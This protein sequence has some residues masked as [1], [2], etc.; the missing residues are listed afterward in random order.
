MHVIQFPVIV[1]VKLS[2]TAIRCNISDFTRSTVLKLR[3]ALPQ[4]NTNN[5]K[6]TELRGQVANTP[7]YSRGSWLKSR[8]GDRL[9][10]LML[11]VVFLSP[12]R[13]MPL[14]YLK[15]I[16]Q[17]RFFSILTNSSFTYDP[18]IRHSIV[19]V[20]EKPSLNNLQTDRFIHV[21]NIPGIG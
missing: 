18:F 6:F 5:T 19:W 3:P 13:Q 17:D 4:H 11:F 7:S 8:P 20:P 15:I 9:Y 1:C 16:C 10:W 12:S 14:Q 21:T 2:Y